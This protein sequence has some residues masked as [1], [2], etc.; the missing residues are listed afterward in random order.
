M[1]I[2]DIKKSYKACLRLRHGQRKTI[3]YD[4]LDRV[5]HVVEQYVEFVENT[6]DEGGGDE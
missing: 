2:E 3:P 5:L 1:S 6:T 4:D